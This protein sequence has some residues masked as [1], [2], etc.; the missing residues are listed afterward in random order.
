MAAAAVLKNRKTA[1]SQQWIDGLLR[2]LAW[3]RT[4]TLSTYQP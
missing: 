1:I 4:L 3:W 2:S